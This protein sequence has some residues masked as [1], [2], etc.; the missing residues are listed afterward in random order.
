MAPYYLYY[1]LNQRQK[2]KKLKQKE[3]IL[4]ILFFLSLLIALGL[5][6]KTNIIL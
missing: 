5:A 6:G 2:C 1:N 4:G 3:I